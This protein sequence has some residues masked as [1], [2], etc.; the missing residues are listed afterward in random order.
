MKQKKFNFLWRD[1]VMD[2][3][4]LPNNEHVP[5][6]LLANKCDLENQQIEDEQI[7]EFAETEG[8]F[9]WFKT[10]AKDNIGIDNAMNSLVDKL[11]E[12]SIEARKPKEKDT[13]QIQDTS[14]TD[15]K[16]EKK[17]QKTGCC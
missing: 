9:K 10:S 6:I 8:F 1:D 12:L 11:I 4:L 17:N 2:K 13:I 14:L 3:V 16:N 7:N 5:M 15:Q